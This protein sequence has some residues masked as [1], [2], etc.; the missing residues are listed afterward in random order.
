M[1]EQYVASF[2]YGSPRKVRVEGIFVSGPIQGKSL[3]AVY[4]TTLSL[5]ISYEQTNVGRRNGH[6]QGVYPISSSH[7]GTQ[8]WPPNTS[9]S[10]HHAQNHSACWRVDEAA[11][12]A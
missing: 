2:L 1:N 11:A 9:L 4:R 8:P 6:G 10:L 3:T 7:C 5:P 12:A